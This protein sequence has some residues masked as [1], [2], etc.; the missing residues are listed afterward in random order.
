MITTVNKVELLGYAGNTPEMV[1]LS[2]KLRLVRFRI[3]TRTR[4]GYNDWRTDW[5]DV[6]AWNE[7]AHSICEQVK[8]G[9]RIQIVGR[10]QYRDVQTKDG[11][12]LRKAE[13]VATDCQIVN[14][15]VRKTTG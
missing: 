14:H 6:I 9:S 2:E 7:L 1:E 11:R 15:Q 10:L 13:V 5:H 4:I 8:K 3:A 12:R